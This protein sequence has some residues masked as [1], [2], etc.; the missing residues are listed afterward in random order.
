M[1]EPEKNEKVQAFPFG[2]AQSPTDTVDPNHLTA[3]A[4]YNTIQLI[5]YS[6]MTKIPETVRLRIMKRNDVF[7]EANDWWSFFGSPSET[8]KPS[9]AQKATRVKQDPVER[10]SEGPRRKRRKRKMPYIRVKKES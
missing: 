1:R 2:A 5:R 6:D 9:H 8:I 4:P 10:S 3:T 7:Q